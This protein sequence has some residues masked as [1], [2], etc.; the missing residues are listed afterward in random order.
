MYIYIC[1]CI[2]AYTHMNINMLYIRARTYSRAHIIN[3]AHYAFFFLG[4]SSGG[5]RGEEDE[6]LEKMEESRE[7]QRRVIDIRYVPV[8]E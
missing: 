4:F 1:I 8:G 7:E 3:R 5:A 2:F 6:R